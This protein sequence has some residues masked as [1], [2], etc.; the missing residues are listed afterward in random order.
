M[1]C[2]QVTHW[3]LGTDNL[4]SVPAEIG[5]HLG[6][7]PRC[8]R[9]R[10]RLRRLNHIV[11]HLPAPVADP[12]ARARLL[13]RI[14]ATPPGQ[15]AVI[16]SR[17]PWRQV[18]SRAAMIALLIGGFSVFALH[19][20]N[21]DPSTVVASETD[22]VGRLVD[23]HVQL[24]EGLP[25][26]ERCQVFAEM[27]Q[28]LRKEA[29]RQAGEEDSS[30]VVALASLY[31]RVLR[32]GVLQRLGRLPVDKQ[33]AIARAVA[34]D[35][36]S[37]ENEAREAVLSARPGSAAALKRI[38]TTSREIGEVLEALG[39]NE[40]ADG[41]LLPAQPLPAEPDVVDTLVETSL[42]IADEADPLDRA[43]G[44]ADAAQVLADAV[45]RAAKRGDTAHAA[46]LKLW[47]TKVLDEAVR[48][49]LQTV[50][51]ESLSGDPLKRWNDLSARPDAILQ[52]LRVDL[53]KL[54]PSVQ[55]AMVNADK[56]A[57]I[58]PKKDKGFDWK[59][60]KKDKKGEKG[61]GKGPPDKG[62]DKGGWEK[63]KGGK[64]G[65]VFFMPP[66]HGPMPHAG[67]PA[68]PALPPQRHPVA[69]LQQTVLQESRAK[70]QRRE[71]NL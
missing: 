40:A 65:K 48:Y 17:R 30:G 18:L 34:A 39:G 58:P 43:S 13:Q 16:V 14:A 45:Q 20:G 15:P 9:R 24:A 50:D 32:Q 42:K 7:C 70:P 4:R 54:N 37:A 29:L 31:D 60:D 55:R 5:A 51:R 12:A 27:A 11:A 10:S 68:P 2:P 19:V 28:D 6:A 64:K 61:K 25:P 57:T 23:C 21:P 26:E 35:M 47:L 66:G 49:N 63:D 36:R 1:N 53:Q 44:S 41:A 52:S 71:D 56:D 38:A 3:L 59:K 62:W 69:V 33:Q 8:R 46:R 67:M 22:F